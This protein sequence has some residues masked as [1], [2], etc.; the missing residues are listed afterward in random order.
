[1]RQGICDNEGVAVVGWRQ[2]NEIGN[3]SGTRRTGLVLQ[4]F[5]VCLDLV[6]V[7]AHFD[8]SG[9]GD[10]EAR[11]GRERLFSGGE[12]QEAQCRV[13]LEARADGLVDDEIRGAVL[14]VAWRG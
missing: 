10:V 12:E 1:V 5:V 7:D 4:A 11:K 6:V 13:G 3:V 14:A 8:L 2:V 9:E